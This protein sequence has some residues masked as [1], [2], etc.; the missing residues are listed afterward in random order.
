MGVAFQ[1]KREDF[2]AF[3]DY[4][5]RETD[6]GKA[7]SKQVFNAKLGRLIMYSIFLGSVLWGVSEKWRAGLVIAIFTFL[8]IGTLEL[9]ISGFSP[10]YYAGIQVY[11]KQEKS[12]TRKE[13]QFFQLRRTITIDETWLEIRSSEALHR[14][15]WRCVDK[16]G[17]TPNFIFIHVGNWPVVYVPKR[18]FPSEQSFI[19]FGNQ[20]AELKEKNKN[21]P[22]GEE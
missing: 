2:Q 8:V 3:Y 15:R 10:I 5:V 13:L 21:Q 12:I 14:W 9:L 18:D 6:Q 7:F 17:L 16:I 1:N 22:I 4:M 20:L 19:E 11:K